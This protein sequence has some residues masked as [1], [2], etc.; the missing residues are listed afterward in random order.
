MRVPRTPSKVIQD[1]VTDWANQR[2]KYELLAEEAKKQCENG[3]DPE[4][5][6][7]PVKCL[8][9]ARAK[10][11]KS[12]QNSIIRREDSRRAQKDKETG[13]II[14]HGPFRDF[15]QIRQEMPDLA[16]IRI[17]LVFPDDDTKVHDFIMNKFEEASPDGPSYWGVDGDGKLKTQHF[18]DPKNRFV[19]YRA[20]HYRV[21]LRDVTPE[22]QLEEN[23]NDWWKKADVEIQ[24]TS[25]TMYA[26]QEVHHDLIYKP[27]SGELTDEEKRTL[28]MV[29]GLVHANEIAL[30][31]FHHS[32]NRRLDEIRTKFRDATNLGHW[33]TIFAIE[34]FHH[35]FKQTS[36]PMKHIELLL[37]VL[38]L[39]DLDTPEKFMDALTETT[40][41]I[42]ETPLQTIAKWARRLE[43]CLR[44]APVEDPE[45]EVEDPEDEVDVSAWALFKICESRSLFR[46][47]AGKDV[48]AL[49]EYILITQLVMEGICTYGQPEE[50][51]HYIRT[52]L[53][54]RVRSSSIIGQIMQWSGQK[55]TD[56]QESSEL[57][58]L[59][60]DEGTWDDLLHLSAGDLTTYSVPQEGYLEHKKYIKDRCLTR[61]VA[62]AVALLGVSAVPV[63]TTQG[64]RPPWKEGAQ[65]IWPGVINVKAMTVFHRKEERKIRAPGPKGPSPPQ[66]FHSFLLLVDGK[67]T[68][69]H[70]VD[71]WGQLVRWMYVRHDMTNLKLSD[72]GPRNLSIRYGKEWLEDWSGVP[73]AN[74][75]PGERF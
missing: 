61:G 2:P 6:A 18:R 65:V 4:T 8:I 63:F 68:R 40:E 10:P 42:V 21:Q 36:P 31:Q 49:Q 5:S 32:L 11:M 51:R 69:L 19:G 46:N 3:F 17:I 33:M 48:T 52:Y 22:S 30:N 60:A 38:Q 9:T 16:G 72:L 57:G 64:W 14:D 34:N 71:A 50:C 24:V 27:Y 67:W 73:Y 44:A 13:E 45:D 39:Y 62:L 55:P 28:D 12:I 43:Q 37:R 1:F 41:E 25:M 58:H 47:T 7:N 35:S 26:W 70:F 23:Y 59:S 20:A 56:H 75:P 29:N 74:L 53:P 66:Q 54:R 15:E